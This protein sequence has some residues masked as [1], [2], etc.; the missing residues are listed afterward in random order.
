M[1]TASPRL[2]LRVSSELFSHSARSCFVFLQFLMLNRGSSEQTGRINFKLYDDVVPKTA[3][4]FR[5]LCTGEKEPALHYK[6]SVF[7]RII[8]EFML[9]GGDFQRGN[10][11]LDSTSKSLS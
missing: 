9:Q 11:R 5:A 7:H 8:P 4:N 2:R 10:V 3:E 1:P 6:G